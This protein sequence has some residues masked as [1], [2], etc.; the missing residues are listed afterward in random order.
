MK[1]IKA[2]KVFNNDW[3]CQGFKYEIGKSYT[4]NGKIKLCSTGFH[5]CEKLHSCFRF[6]DCVPWNKIAEVELSGE[7]L[8]IG[9]EKCCAS[10]IK[11]IREINFEEIGTEIKNNISNGVNNSFGVSSSFGVNKSYGINESFGVSRSYGVNESYGVNNSF[12]VNRSDGVNESY[13][14]NES[15]GIHN[16]FGVNE[17]DGVHNSNGVN[18]SNGVSRSY[19]VNSSDGVN[20]SYGVNRSFGI[21]ES[22]GVHNSHGIFNGMFVSNKGE[23]FIFFNKKIKKERYEE[24][25]S[26]LFAKLNGWTPTFN[27]LRYLYIKSGKDWKK[28]PIPNA[29]GLQKDAAWKD[30][31]KKAIEYLKSLPEFDPKIFLEVT[32]IWLEA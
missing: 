31:P 24:I 7:I 17:S 10:K 4:H 14:V 11:I 30:M 32:G 9:Y 16:S 26:N 15:D 28:T 25:R 6:Y 3:T 22:F 8:G 5:A 19:G 27:N 13:G 21:N 12:G 2:Y 20:K 18:S 1:K 29:D 23:S